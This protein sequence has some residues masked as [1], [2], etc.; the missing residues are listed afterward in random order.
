MLT[1]PAFLFYMCAKYLTAMANVAD[2]TS[3]RSNATAIKVFGRAEGVCEGIVIDEFWLKYLP[4]S[5][6]RAQKLLD[7][8]RRDIF[9]GEDKVCETLS[10][11][12]MEWIRNGVHAFEISL[13]DEIGNM[14]LFCCEDSELGNLSI[15]KLLKGASNGY[16]EQTRTKLTPEC[17][18][19]IDEAGKW[20]LPSSMQR[21]DQHDRAGMA[22]A[23]RTS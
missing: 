1:A 23:G 2:G 4:S 21:S 19:E 13:C 8:I 14:P 3:M 22:W 15:D 5:V 10:A 7:L 9:M 16:P 17:L 20:K 11:T 12:H 6:K 18:T